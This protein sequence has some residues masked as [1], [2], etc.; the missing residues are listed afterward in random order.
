MKKFTRKKKPVTTRKKK[1]VTGRKVTR[2]K[3]GPLS[4]PFAVDDMSA[5]LGRFVA[6]Y[7][8]PG[9]GKTTT[10]SYAPK[11]LFV[12]TA[13]EKGIHEALKAGVVPDISDWVVTLDA[14]SAPD[15]IPANSGHP[16]WNKLLS[17]MDLFLTG[18]HDRRT[19]V[20]DT[21]SGLQGLCYQHCASVL[22][23]G[24]MLDPKG[25]MNYQEGYR[26][27][28]EQFWNGEFLARCNALTNAGYNVILLCHSKVYNVPN[29][30]GEDYLCYMPSLAK[31]GKQDGIYEYTT[32][33][34][35]AI[36]FMGEHTRAEAETRKGKTKKVKSQYGFIGT[37]GEG[38]FVAKNWFNLQ[39]DIDTG[40]TAKETFAN[41]NEHLKLA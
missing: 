9:I 8:P 14:L 40:A 15:D 4:N 33:T 21:G 41:L 35:S 27:A 29:P 20:I 23:K 10:A 24:D 7:G 1:P 37:R 5:P 12:C 3:T 16:G 25:F 34:V 39:Q 18:E 19:L 6:L 22:Y 30:G 28:A 31:G 17:T 26:K 36:L 13:D 2:A 32:K 11:P 38:W